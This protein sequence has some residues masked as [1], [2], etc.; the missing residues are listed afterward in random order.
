[1]S[2]LFAS[3][4]IGYVC[5]RTDHG[6][7][8]INTALNSFKH[9][10]EI[11]EMMPYDSRKNCRRSIETRREDDRRTVY[12]LFGTQEWIDNIKNHYLSWPKLDRRENVRRNLERRAIDRRLKQLNEQDRS[13]IQYSQILLT[14]EERKLIA[15]I[16][17]VFD[18]V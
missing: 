16:Y 14:Q 13:A 2:G 17:A 12:Y 1:M 10:K 3:A 9:A 8:I 18:T 11:F 15:D 7:L 6:T 4:P 5:F